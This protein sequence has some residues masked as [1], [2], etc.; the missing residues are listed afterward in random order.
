[1]QI[2]G[3][4]HHGPGSARS[5]RQALSV[6]QPDILLVEGPPDADTVLSLVANTQLEPPVA[7]LVYAPDALKLA[8]Y[9]PFACFSPEWQAIQYG[10]T[11][12]IPV[13]FMDLP[14]THQFAQQKARDESQ[15]TAADATEADSS[16]SSNP[17]IAVPIDVPEIADDTS[18][19]STREAET[20]LI[21]KIRRD[22]LSWLAEAAGYADGERWVGTY[23][24]TAAG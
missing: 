1:M 24:G 21:R 5:L 20:P 17:D 19:E 3:I 9:Y 23:G 7:L 6:M 11:Q 13:R 12:N 8:A 22:P 2:F 15:M 18:G 10:L 14:Q 16:D 4:R